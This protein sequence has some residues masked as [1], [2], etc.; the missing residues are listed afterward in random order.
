MSL[1]ADPSDKVGA[2]ALRLAGAWKSEDLRLAMIRIAGA[3]TVGPERRQAAVAALVDLGDLTSVN[4]LARIAAGNKPFA[5]RR[6]AAIGL[7][8]LDTRKAAD[9]AGLLLHTSPPAGEDVEPLFTAFLRQKGGAAALADVFKAQTPA[10]DAARVGM[11]VLAG[12]G[13]QAPELTAA[14]QTATGQVGLKRKLDAAELQR[15]TKLVQT[16]GDPMRGEAVFRR[17]EL[18]C[19]QCH[20]LGGAGG[21]VGPDLSGIGT[22]A[23]LD[24]LIESVILP[25]KVVR[26]GFTTAVVS[27]LDGKTYSGVVQRESATEL[28]LRDPIRDEIV[29]PVKEIEEKRIGGSLMPEGLDHTLTDAELADVVRFLSE[30]G[31]PGPFAVTHIRAARTWQRLASS[32]ERLLVLDDAAL[33]AVLRN[34]QTLAW[35]PLYSQVS[36]NLPLRDALAAPDST[37]IFAR[38]T[39]EVT[40]AGKLRLNLGDARAVALWVDGMATQARDAVTLDLAQGM[41]TLTFRVD[42]K[43]RPDPHLRCELTDVPGSPAQSRFVGGR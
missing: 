28:V 30:L 19:M 26:E 9:L 15:L 1:F 36:G 5:V 33:S 10:K 14:L 37:A 17:P 13:V 40:T 16:E 6:D 23:Q 29:I 20:A 24:Y 21:K 31:R 8:A 39:L 43:A 38:C 7:A 3:N 12:L 2:A 32:P 42:L 4:D 34:D 27:T 41:H 22:S 11:R 25:S 35:A 18:G